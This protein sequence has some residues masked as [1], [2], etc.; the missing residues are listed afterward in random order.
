ML[1]RQI[2]GWVYRSTSP[3][4]FLNMTDSGGRL[5]MRWETTITTVDSKVG[6]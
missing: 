1:A 2:S 4:D 6:Q 3:I 5:A